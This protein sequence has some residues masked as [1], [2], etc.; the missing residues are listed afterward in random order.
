MPNGK[1]GD[2]PLTDRLI[3]R[4]AAR[5]QLSIGEPFPDAAYNFVAPA[6]RRDGS[7]AVLKVFPPGGEYELQSAALRRV[8]GNGMV[9]L[10]EDWPA[11]HAM[12]IERALPGAPIFNLGDD[13]AA[14][15]L[16]AELL[17]HIWVD[18]PPNHPFPTVRDWARGFDR[19]RS[20]FDGATSPFPRPLV[21]RAEAVYQDLL[22]SSGT[23]K[24][25]HGDFHHWNLLS[26]RR[27]PWLAIDPKGL[28]GEP[29]YEPG[30]W[31]R[32]AFP[33]GASL[34]ELK[35]YTA[36]RIDQFSELLDFDRQRL[37]QW[38]FAQAVLSTWWGYEDGDP[39][40]AASL[41]IADFF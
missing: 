19:L 28:V 34:A 32:N 15:R 7:Q 33:P 11:Q 30:A 38:G 35:A 36:R 26:A 37:R 23:P 6:A 2:H 14:T 1:P 16:A 27:A 17:P 10:L 25:L 3:K 9:R 4:I 12:L 5:W 22:E 29:E 24:L 13:E 40:W 39:H 8:D 31:L 41:E 18:P 21:G 20:A